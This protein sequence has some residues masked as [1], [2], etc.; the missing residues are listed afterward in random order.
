[1][2][3]IERRSGRDRPWRARYRGPDGQE[4]SRSFFRKRDAERWLAS[5]E[6]AKAR[7]EWVDPKLGRTTVA[8]WAARW[9]QTTVDLRPSSRA[10][11]ESYYRNHI[12]PRFGNIKLAA[13]DHL[14]VREWIAELSD[15]GL[16]PATVRKAHQVLSKILR[17]AVDDGLLASSPCERQRLPKIEHH[18]MR[19]LTPGEVAQLADA[20]DQRYRNL[21]LVGAYGGLR[22]GELFGLRR[23]RVELMTGR[24]DVAEIAVEVRGRHYFGPPKTQAGRRSVPLPRFVVD[25][26]TRQA[27][28]LGPDQL[29]F[30]APEGGPIRGSLFRRRF[31]LPAI[32]AAG[33]AP[34]RL[35][36]LRH[37]AVAFWIAAGASPK[38]IAVRAGHSSVAVVLDRYGHLLPGTEE[39]VTAALDEFARQVHG[40]GARRAS[41]VELR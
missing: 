6:T 34:L 12:A 4:R 27:G 36:D 25:E 29:V 1:M 30:A 17:A 7:G 37:T 33:V 13:V 35:H 32:D 19:F 24:V 31:W 20:I 39:R 18:E 11:D 15:Q 5:I 38:E 40:N 26:L 9:W 16:A 14:T 8:E 2:A 3:H 28:P 41:V 22:A 21:V 23:D 10:R